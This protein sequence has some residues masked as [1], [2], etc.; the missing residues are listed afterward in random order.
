MQE[1]LYEYGA[2]K[3]GI[4]EG[5]RHHYA[6][7]IPDIT[8]P[9][10]SALA[11][12][13]SSW[14]TQYLQWTPEQSKD[15]AI[16]DAVLRLDPDFPHD[17]P[18]TSLNREN[19]RLLSEGTS[20]RDE[21]PMLNCPICDHP[22]RNEVKNVVQLYEFKNLIAG[23][24][25]HMIGLLDMT[26]ENTVHWEG[27]DRETCEHDATDFLA[28]GSRTGFD[29]ANPIVQLKAANRT[30][31]KVE[32]EDHHRSSAK[33]ILQQVKLVVNFTQALL[34]SNRY[35]PRWLRTMRRF[36]CSAAAISI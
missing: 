13:T 17:C 26:Y 1:V 7:V 31:T 8:L 27:C 24:Y 22:S 18:Y 25:E 34:N 3:V 14:H 4:E 19:N 29:A 5:I 35:G 10:V 11:F 15:K 28:T 9:I 12:E 23:S 32:L 20:I 33:H 30:K 21:T 6:K 36:G 2:P 16:A